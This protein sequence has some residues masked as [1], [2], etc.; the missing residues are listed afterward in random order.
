MARGRRDSGRRDSQHGLLNDLVET[1]DAS[2]D[3]QAENGDLVLTVSDYGRE[4]EI[5][6]RKSGHGLVT[7]RR[8]TRSLCG[9]LEID[10]APDRGT[11][12]KFTIQRHQH[13]QNLCLGTNP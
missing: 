11:E 7:M 10:S 13:E 12:L 3:L 1:R 2:S 9:A 4:F 5:D 6:E 8:R